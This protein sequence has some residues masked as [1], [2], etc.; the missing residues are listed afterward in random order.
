MH[1]IYRWFSLPPTVFLNV[2][3]TTILGL[4]A[5][6]FPC[7]GQ[8][9]TITRPK[10][11]VTIHHPPGTGITLQ[12]KKVAFG[13][14]SGP[15]AQQ[16]SDLLV[17]VFQANHVEVV[18][19]Q[20]LDSLLTEHRFQVGASV[21]PT[22]AV[23]LGK[24]LG[25]SVMIFVSV[26]RCSVERNL[27][28]E[29]QFVGPPVN[30][31]RTDAHFLASVHTTDLATGRELAVQSLETNP[32]KENRSTNGIAEYPG[33]VEVQD[34]AV[35]EA[36]TK[37]ERLYFPWTEIRQLAFMN[38]KECNLKAAY[39]TLR[40][41]D[42]AGALKLSRE[43]VEACKSDPKTGHQSD[44]WY[45][46]GIAYFVA[47][48][49]DNALQAMNEANKLHSDKTILDAIAG[50]RQ[51]IADAKKAADM[52]TKQSTAAVEEQGKQQQRVQE[53]AKSTLTNDTIIGQ[54][55]DGFSAELILHEIASQ[56][57]KFSVTPGDLSA[58][59]KAGVPDSVIAAMLDKK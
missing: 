14:I 29:K 48:D 47:D 6:T 21:D 35:H 32:R 19:R 16:F 45:N 59:K 25:P 36:A 55:K 58:L 40:A 9:I 33:E 49:Y 8:L 30:V 22:T 7:H 28:S 38:G 57:A 23:A 34:V 43:N 4:L 10:V 37:A 20:Q 46:L 17:P 53:E 27:L 24:V 1:A 39:D 26:A 15:C 13:Q 11:P 31:S 2:A 5:T 51:Q 54:V 18:N 42:N 12:G 52:D 3:A 56:P 41:G 50:I 44:A